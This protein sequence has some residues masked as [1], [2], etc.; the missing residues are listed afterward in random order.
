MN[1]IRAAK[2]RALADE[3]GAST[4]TVW[5]WLRGQHVGA[6]TDYAL[7]AACRALK[8]RAPRKRTC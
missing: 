3:T 1:V 8:L 2:C 5:R 4:K 6:V 7:R